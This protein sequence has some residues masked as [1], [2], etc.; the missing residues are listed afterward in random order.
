MKV[1]KNFKSRSLWLWE[2]LETFT[3]QK[4]SLTDADKIGAVCALI[5]SASLIV[6][7]FGPWFIGALSVLSSTVFYG[8]RWL[9]K[10]EELEIDHE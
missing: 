5:I 9:I 10:Q 4:L 7:F 3:E 6:L 1:S 8:V 2:K